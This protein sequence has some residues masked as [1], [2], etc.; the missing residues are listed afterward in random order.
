VCVGSLE[1]INLAH[2]PTVLHHHHHGEAA[3]QGRRHGASLKM[4]PAMTAQRCCFRAYNNWI[5]RIREDDSGHSKSSRRYGKR[6]CQS[7]F[8]STSVT[9]RSNKLD[10][11]FSSC[12]HCEQDVSILG[13]PDWYRF[14][15]SHCFRVYPGSFLLPDY[16]AFS[17][18]MLAL[19]HH[20]GV[21]VQWSANRLFAGFWFHVSN[22]SNIIGTTCIA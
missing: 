18:F 10:M 17:R 21:G 12:Y 19:Q 16:S 6:P 9:I 7:H 14:V 13:A 2:K 20:V 3:T 15:S 8:R 4:R 11:S 5:W 22:S 1:W